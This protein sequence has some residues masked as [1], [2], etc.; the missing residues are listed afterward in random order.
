MVH[1]AAFLLIIAFATA[2]MSEW[3]SIGVLG[4]VDTYVKPDDP[5]TRTKAVRGTKLLKNLH[6]SSVMGAFADA[7]V[8]PQW[9]DM[10]RK[11]KVFAYEPQQ[12]TAETAFAKSLEAVDGEDALRDISVL[13]QVY[14]FPWPI[15]ARDFCLLRQFRYDADRK[16]VEIYYES[17]LDG[18][19]PVD[20]SNIRGTNIYSRFFFRSA[21]EDNATYCEIETQVDLKGSLPP[22]VIN[23]VQRLWPTKTINALEA[24]ARRGTVPP[25]ARVSAW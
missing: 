13:H 1:L 9:V 20:L 23:L 18:R 16:E 3:Q 10:L 14:S 4:G 17:I 8:N 6:I 5:V 2:A 12:C 25:L 22:A 24:L 15:Q 19:V 11:M 7:S 21:P